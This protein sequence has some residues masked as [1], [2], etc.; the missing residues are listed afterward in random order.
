MSKR[1]KKKKDAFT[2]QQQK[3]P[4]FFPPDQQQHFSTFFIV[5]SL[6]RSPYCLRPLPSLLIVLHHASRPRFEGRSLAG[7]IAV[8]KLWT[9][10]GQ[11][12]GP[13]GIC[14]HVR[15]LW[16]AASLI[17]DQCV[18]ALQ[19]LEEH[20]DWQKRA[21]HIK[22]THFLCAIAEPRTIVFKTAERD[23]LLTCPQQHGSTGQVFLPHSLLARLLA[24]CSCLP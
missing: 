15:T 13:S 5:L 23:V 9:C 4:P 24:F 22:W 6:S 8:Y 12:S 17:P 18:S 10:R 21:A 7:V 1:K 11:L 2:L 14:K 20:K 16:N 3:Q 19:A